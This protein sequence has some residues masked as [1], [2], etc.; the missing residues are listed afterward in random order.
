MTGDDV[1]GGSL[2]QSGPLLVRVTHASGESALSQIARLV[3]EAEG[4]KAPIQVQCIHYTIS[5]QQ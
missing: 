1:I 3:S 5:V 4:S 2:N